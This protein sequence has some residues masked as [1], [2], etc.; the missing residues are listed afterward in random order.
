[1]KIKHLTIA[2]LLLG[3]TA[4]A[5]DPVTDRAGSVAANVAT[6]SAAG[7]DALP[8]APEDTGAHYDRDDW[9]HWAD[10][11]QGD[12]C[13]AREETL[14]DQGKEVRTGDGC[15]VLSGIWLSVYDGVI[16]TDPRALDVDHVVPLA[17]VARSGRIVDGRRVGPREW[18]REQRRAYANDLRVLVAVTARSNRSKGDDDPARWLPADKR[19]WYVARWVAVKSLYELSVDQAEHDAIAS[20]QAGCK[21]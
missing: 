13:D 9:P 2:F 14:L 21:G 11:G 8:I 19:C 10:S 1:M 18:T 7:L 6:A 3:A 5:A 4:C 20:V 16:V 15:K 17:E 12:G